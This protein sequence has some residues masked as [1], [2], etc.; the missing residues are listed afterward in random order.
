MGGGF[1][2]RFAAANR[3]TGRDVV[4]GVPP[5]SGVKRLD[6]QRMRGIALWTLPIAR[7]V[8]AGIR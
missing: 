6:H 8:A 2:S 1:R 3:G 5:T 4:E 7:K